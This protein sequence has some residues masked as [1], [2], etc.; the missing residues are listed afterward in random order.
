M[1]TIARQAPLSSTIS[2]VCSNSCP[3]SLWGCLTISFSAASFSFCLQS[4]PASGSFPMSQLFTSGGQSIGASAFSISLFNEYSGLISFWIDWFHLL[5][6]QGILKSLL[7]HHNV[8]ILILRCSIKLSH[9]Y[10]TTGKTTAL[11]I[12]IF[13]TKVTSLVFNILSVLSHFS[14]VRLFVTLRT[15]AC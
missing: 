8:K 4:F 6:V 3:L 5:A 2:Q 12:C 1:W 13:V 9:L 11:T 15:V 14:R 10:M 7:Q